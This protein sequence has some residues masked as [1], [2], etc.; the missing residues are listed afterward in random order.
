M[1]E[2]KKPKLRKGIEKKVIHAMKFAKAKSR[3]RVLTAINTTIKSIIYSELK[4]IPDGDIEYY[5]DKI[6][7]TL[8][9]I[10]AII[11]RQYDWSQMQSKMLS[12][13]DKEIES[14]KIQLEVSLE[15]QLEAKKD[16][17]DYLKEIS[18]LK[19]EK[20]NFSERRFINMKKC[21]KEN[22]EKCNKSINA[23][24]RQ[25]D[26]VENE[27]YKLQ[28]ELKSIKDK[29]YELIYGVA[30]KYKDESR[31]ETALRYIMS[32]ENNNTSTESTEGNNNE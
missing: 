4:D 30:S 16:E 1:K 6:N 26:K 14:L 13:K 25:R 12:E 8:S 28:V 19:K 29:Y 7:N 11:T 10:M 5:E 22:N 2:Y 24:L 9:P 20:G 17:D 15:N 3:N 18:E 23:M 21:I 27:N 32:C 31:H